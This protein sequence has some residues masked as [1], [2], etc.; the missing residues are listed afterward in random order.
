MQGLPADGGETFDVILRAHAGGDARLDPADSGGAED[1]DVTG[2]RPDEV[3][4]NFVDKQLVAAFGVATHDGLAGAERTAG[5][6]LEIGPDNVE[7]RGDVV[8]PAACDDFGRGEKMETGDFTQP[9]DRIVVL[10]AEINIGAPAQDE[11]GG[12]QGPARRWVDRARAGHAIKRRLHGSGGNFERLEKVSPDAKGDDEGD[13][14]DLGVFPQA[15]QALLGSRLVEKAMKFLRGQRDILAVIFPQSNLEAGDAL[16]EVDDLLV[17]QN[18]PPVTQQFA[19]RAEDEFG[20]FAVTRGQKQH[21]DRRM[22]FSPPGRK[23]QRRSRQAN[24]SLSSRR[25]SSI[26]P[27]AVARC[28]RA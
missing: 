9:D 7:R 11:F 6:D 3:V 5:V 18:V 8:S 12:A 4:G 13:E 28:E 1:K 17:R 23:R 15:G 24:C 14:D 2:F 19:G 25:A 20:F 10:R 16:A 22:Q 21:T 27:P 26:C